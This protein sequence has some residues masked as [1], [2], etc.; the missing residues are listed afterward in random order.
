[1]SYSVTEAVAKSSK[2]LWRQ[3]P[4]YFVYMDLCKGILFVDECK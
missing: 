4:T 2:F 1:V 3:T